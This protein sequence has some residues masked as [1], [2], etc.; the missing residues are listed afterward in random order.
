MTIEILSSFLQY[1][2]QE[3]DFTVGATDLSHQVYNIVTF[4]YD[5]IDPTI[6]TGF[7]IGTFQPMFHLF[8]ARGIDPDRL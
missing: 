1:L 3:Y 5:A 4:H 6:L 7:D 2:V 8:Q